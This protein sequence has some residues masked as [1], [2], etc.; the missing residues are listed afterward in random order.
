MV[1]VVKRYH[2]SIIVATALVTAVII[3]VVSGAV[4]G[5]L[6]LCGAPVMMSLGVWLGAGVGGV[7]MTWWQLFK[8]WRKGMVVDE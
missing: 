7:V 2:A 6:L 5:L 4:T 3:A 1:Q 8:I